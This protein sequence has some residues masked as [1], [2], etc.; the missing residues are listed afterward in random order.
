MEVKIVRKRNTACS[1]NDIEEKLTSTVS[2]EPCC[3]KITFGSAVQISR[4]RDTVCSTNIVKDEQ[5]DK[6]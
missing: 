1:K 3:L 2:E 4:K 5:Q 6:V